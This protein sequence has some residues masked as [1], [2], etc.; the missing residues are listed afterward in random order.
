MKVNDGPVQEEIKRM[1]GYI[2]TTRSDK[3]NANGEIEVIDFIMDKKLDFCLGNAV[4][5]ICRYAAKVGNKTNNILDIEK[6]IHFLFME[7]ANRRER[8]FNDKYSTKQNETPHNLK[9]LENNLNTGISNSSIED[10]SSESNSVNAFGAPSQNISDMKIPDP[11]PDFYL[12]KNENEANK[13]LSDLYNYDPL[14]SGIHL[15]V[16]DG[17]GIEIDFFEQASQ[18][19]DIARSNR[20]KMSRLD[21]SLKARIAKDKELRKSL[22]DNGILL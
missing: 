7:L 20:I 10:N 15:S 1:L 12:P 17:S 14:V 4:K 16:D 2:E 11:D 18:L 5:Y 13:V 8:D 22:E 3:Y 9:G 6:A 21:Q 19:D